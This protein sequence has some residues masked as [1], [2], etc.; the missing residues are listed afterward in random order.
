[1]SNDGKRTFFN[2]GNNGAGRIISSLHSP[3]GKN[4][5]GPTTPQ[6]QTRL[7]FVSNFNNGCGRGINL[8]HEQKSTPSEMP[9]PHFPQVASIYISVREIKTV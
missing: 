5:S 7:G 1:M 6:V 2:I 3:I 9:A 8:L 4:S